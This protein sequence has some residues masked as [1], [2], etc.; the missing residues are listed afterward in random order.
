MKLWWIWVFL[1]GFLSSIKVKKHKSKQD[2]SKENKEL[3]EF[4]NVKES[5][6]R[7]SKDHHHVYK[8]ITEGNYEKQDMGYHHDYSPIDENR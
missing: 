6:K 5:G 7:E 1:V 4:H 3:Y 2:E 8:D